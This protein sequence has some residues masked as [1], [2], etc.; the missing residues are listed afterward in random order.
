MLDTRH[1]AT[2]LR[3]RMSQNWLP[4]A[5][6]VVAGLDD[7]GPTLGELG[8]RGVYRRALF[9]EERAK[10]GVVEMAAVAKALAE[11]VEEDTGESDQSDWAD[12]G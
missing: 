8:I 2:R 12:F 11:S 6:G 3:S 10:R 5:A 7:P 4:K 1:T 9:A